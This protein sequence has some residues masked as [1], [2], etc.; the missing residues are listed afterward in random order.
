MQ[1]L[2]RWVVAKVGASEDLSEIQEI[3]GPSDE[4]P[5]RSMGVGYSHRGGE[6]KCSLGCERAKILLFSG[7]GENNVSLPSEN[8]FFLRDAR[9]WCVTH[10]THLNTPKL[11]RNFLHTKFCSLVL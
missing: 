5:V 2:I 7:G 8:R 3:Q 1:S 9:F 4:A 11:T 6:N 10:H